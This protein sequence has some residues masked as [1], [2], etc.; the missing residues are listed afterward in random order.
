MNDTLIQIA[1]LC[2]E[3]R[4]EVYMLLFSSALFT[5]LLLIGGE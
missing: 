2:L 5:S 4:T 1:T 3:Y